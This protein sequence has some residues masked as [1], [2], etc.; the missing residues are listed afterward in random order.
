MKTQRLL[1]SLL[2]LYF[3]AGIGLTQPE[4][5]PPNN[6]SPM[7]QAMEEALHAV[8]ERA[9]LKASLRIFW[10][11]KDSFGVMLFLDDSDICEALGISE[12]QIQQFE[13]KESHESHAAM[14]EQIRASMEEGLDKG[15]KALEKAVEEL[16]E[17]AE[18]FDEAT[19]LEAVANIENAATDQLEAMMSFE[20]VQ[21]IEAMN[22]AILTPERIQKLQEIE[23][24]A[25]RELPFISPS[26]FEAL[27][28]TDEQ[29]EEMENIKEEL[30]PEFEKNLDDF[31]KN[32]F[33]LEKI[34][35]SEYAKEP[36]N[37]E[38]GQETREETRKRLM[39]E[40]PEYKR[41]QEEI[42]TRSRAFSTQFRTR[43][44]DVLNDEQWDRLQELIDYPPEYA[45]MFIKKLR[46]SSGLVESEKSDEEGGEGGLSPSVWLPG[47]GSWRPG[48]GVPE[49]YRQERNTRRTF[50]RPEN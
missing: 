49:A 27:N 16:R 20:I 17:N 22:D 35:E 15:G 50:P 18:N 37:S 36:K 38:G 45:L 11:S 4:E 8:E 26:A 48:D 3:F 25:M 21:I 12:E 42:Q 33:A 39:A 23:L 28:L 13:F 29:R 44:F 41:M 6:V 47:P 30:N 24:A 1:L 32:Y 40:N 5:Q 43:M 14:M 2:C 7:R 31:V 10:N 9:E 46:E 19:M 34:L